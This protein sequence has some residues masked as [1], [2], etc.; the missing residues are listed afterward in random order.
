MRLRFTKPALASLDRVLDYIH[1]Q[2][3]GGAVS[4]ENRIKNTL[5]LIS[6]YPES[7]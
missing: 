6:T 1:S 5:K 7:G 4:V 3:P 2:S